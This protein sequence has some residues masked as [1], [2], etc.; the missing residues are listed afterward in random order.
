MQSSEQPA[1]V[2]AAKIGAWYIAT[3]DEALLLA[4][5]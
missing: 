5:D 2:R 4:R 3:I 1:A